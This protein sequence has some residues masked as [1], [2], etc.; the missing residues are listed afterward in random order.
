M[1]DT[2]QMDEQVRDLLEE[3]RS[4]PPL[5]LD[6]GG[7]HRDRVNQLLEFSWGPP[8]EEVAFTDEHVAGAGG[9]PVRVK[10]YA[11]ERA[12]EGEPFPALI[13]LH[14]GGMVLGSPEVEDRASRALANALGCKV[15]APA[16]RLAPEWPHPAAVEDCRTA[17][18]WVA[19]NAEL[20]EVEAARM[21]VLGHSAGGMLALAC[22]LDGE[23]QGRLDRIVLIEPMVGPGIE[24]E[25]L[26][27]FASGYGLSREELERYWSLYLGEGSVPDRADTPWLATDAEL[28]VLPRVDVFT[29][30]LD[31][32]RDEGEQ[33]VGGL[34]GAGVSVTHRRFRG[35]I[36]GSISYCGRVDAAGRAFEAVI[37]SLRSGWQG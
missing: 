37:D 26:V 3:S 15:F 27:R 32:L 23:M 8:Y 6:A 35:L 13:R 31:P 2:V 36:H 1:T 34:R 22:G 5:R 21:A 17:C 20:L 25:S 14:G 11:P 18:R 10:E 30:E 16:Y 28:S 9:Y 4:W 12:R 33:L 29:S 24:T 7:M 19:A